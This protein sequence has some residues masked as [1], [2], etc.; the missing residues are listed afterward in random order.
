[1]SVATWSDITVRIASHFHFWSLNFIIRSQIQGHPKT[2]IL[3]MNE[4][5][6][7]AAN[8]NLLTSRGIGHPVS[9]LRCGA[10]S[11]TTMTMTVDGTKITGNTKVST[12]P[13][14]R[15]LNTRMI[16]LHTSLN[17]KLHLSTR[18]FPNSR[19]QTHPSTRT[20]RALFS[21]VRFRLRLPLSFLSVSCKVP[22][23]CIIFD[24][25][26]LAD[27]PPQQQEEEKKPGWFSEHKKELEVCLG[28][29]DIFCVHDDIPLYSPGR[30]SYRYSPRPCRR[31]VRLNE[32]S[33]EVRG[34]SWY[35]SSLPFVL[36]AYI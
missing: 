23:N 4:I 18:T 17:T 34:R 15:G 22:M 1:M 36:T 31:W 32:A 14:T 33:R 29:T 7:I 27:K 6:C 35:L 30:R 3:G 12:S 21:K 26:D 2:F 24:D 20:T 25:P 5:T 28:F 8:R 16:K 13:S 19:T 10:C 9:L 11:R